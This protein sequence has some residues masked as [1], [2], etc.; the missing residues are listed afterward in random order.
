MTI[1]YEQV[2]SKVRPFAPIAKLFL[3]LALLALRLLKI[4][5]E[6]AA[7]GLLHFFWGQGLPLQPSMDMRDQ[8]RYESWKLVWHYLNGE[9]SQGWT[10]GGGTLTNTWGGYN[11][12]IRPKQG[13]PTLVFEAWDI[14]DWNRGSLAIKDQPGLIWSRY[15]QV[16]LVK[17]RFHFEWSWREAELDLLLL[18]ISMWDDTLTVTVVINDCIW[19]AL[20]GK[21]YRQEYTSECSI[22]GYLAGLEYSVG[23]SN[24]FVIIVPEDFEA[25]GFQVAQPLPLQKF[26]WEWGTEPAWTVLYDIPEAG[27][28]VGCMLWAKPQEE[29]EEE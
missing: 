14:Y 25:P 15:F 27:Y 26:Y 12:S 23:N 7:T 4:E 10:L 16:P 24:E 28:A 13:E 20:G 1:S 21:A 3:S 2:D 29:E 11:Y 19:D 8:L 22:A 6:E 9:E 18:H 17:S 5:E